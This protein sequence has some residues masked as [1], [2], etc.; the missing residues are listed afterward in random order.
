MTIQDEI[1][2]GDVGMNEERLAAIPTYFGKAYLDSG[3]LPC[4][5]TIVSRNGQIIHEA[6][7]GRTRLDGGQPVEAAQV[8]ERSPSPVAAAARAAG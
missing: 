3:K 2:A 1:S 4:M 6:Y 8:D 5:A 7:R